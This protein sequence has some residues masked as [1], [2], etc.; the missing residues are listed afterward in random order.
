MAPDKVAR[1]TLNRISRAPLV[2]PGLT[3]KIAAFFMQHLLTRKMAAAIMEMQCK[4]LIRSN[5]RIE[6]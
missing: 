2:I 4:K 5:D 6:R 3:N 1:L